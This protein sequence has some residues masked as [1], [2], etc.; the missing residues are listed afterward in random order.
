[1][2]NKAKKLLSLEFYCLCVLAFS[3]PLFESLKNLSCLIY[4]ILFTFRVLKYKETLSSPIKGR[5]ILIFILG[6]II[7][8]IGAAYNDYEVLKLHDVIRYS[9]IGWLILNTPLTNKQLYTVCLVLAA[10]TLI[11]STEA[12]FL[13]E[14]GKER[15]FEL[16]S[17][18]HINHSSI[19][20]LLILGAT[21]PALI[22][23]KNTIQWWGCLFFNVS[24]LY[25]FLQTN[26]RAT[27]IGLF[28]IITIL[29]L[30]TC[31][32]Y[33]KYTPYILLFCLFL[34]TLVALNPPN[35]I[36]KF[37]NNQKYYSGKVTPRE[38]A[39]NTSYYAWKKEIL[40]GV[41][42]G[43]YQSITEEKF[44]E[45]YPKEEASSP[46]RQLL[47]YLPH[48]HN[49]YMNTLAES[50]AVGLI[51]LIILLS[52]ILYNLIRAIP[53]IRSSNKNLFFWLIGLNTLSTVS[54]VGLFNTTLHHEHGL[55]TM[56]LIGVCFN[57]LHA[58]STSTR[59]TT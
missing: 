16:K 43:N 42:L 38:K 11:A 6:N 48:A 46:D 5:Y 32:F 2:E 57:F 8:S 30:Y 14:T 7:A 47:T 34:F 45:W 54:V 41:G 3:L 23:M 33:R 19:Y 51:S 25:F 29:I 44:N 27:F 39:W 58:N 24:V 13:V 1:M 31:Y 50:G 22:Y 20:I 36:K 49:R 59:E 10:A 40:F 26:S 15:F 18:G 4:L 37:I 52:A 56:I 35:V 28:L 12:Y 21:L 53:L 55:L 9:L 17:V